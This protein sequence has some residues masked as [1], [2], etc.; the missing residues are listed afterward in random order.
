[1]KNGF[2]VKQH[3]DDLYFDLNERG[4]RDFASTVQSVFER[5]V[6]EE[7][8]DAMHT[9]ERDFLEKAWKWSYQALSW[10]VD[11]HVKSNTVVQNYCVPV[12]VPSSQGI[13]V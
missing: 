9:I 12:Y 4:Q 10:W 6:I 13:V 8:E 3:G 2:L 11:A 5:I 1:M 7:L